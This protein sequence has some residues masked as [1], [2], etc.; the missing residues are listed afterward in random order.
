[1]VSAPRTQALLSIALLLCLHPP[2][3]RAQRVSGG[4][5][6]TSQEQALPSVLRVESN[7]VTVRVVVR[8]KR[9]RAMGG[10]KREDFALFDN[11][12]AQVITHFSVEHRGAPP[13]TAPIAAP[14]ETST[15]A[16][17]RE[18]K[19]AQPSP[20]R[21]LAL[22]FDD[23]HA[24]QGDLN[25]VS[26]AA[27]QYL[28]MA[29]RT[30]ERVGVFTTSGHGELDFTNDLSRLDTAIKSLV[31]RPRHE[32]RPCPPIS[33]YQAYLI[34][35]MNDPTAMDLALSLM[36]NQCATLP[37]EG[38]AHM[39]SALVHYVQ[40]KAHQVLQESEVDARQTFDGFSRVVEHLSERPG[41]RTLLLAS[42]GFYDRTVDY[43]LDPVIDR[44]MRERIVVSAL[45][46]TGLLNVPLFSA[47]KRGIPIGARLADGIRIWQENMAANEEP[48]AALVEATGGDFFHN[49]NDYL[50]G[51]RQI[52]EPPEVLYHLAF[53]PS[54]IKYDGK[55]HEIKVKLA[56]PGG[57]SVQARRGY[58]ALREPL[59]ENQQAEM[60]IRQAIFSTAESKTV[61]V[62][63]ST[64]FFKLEPQKARV[65]LRVR[66]DPRALAFRDDQGRKVDELRITA[67]VFDNSG[68][69]V[70][71]KQKNVKMRFDE[72]GLAKLLE[73]PGGV[74]A[75][76]NLDLAPGNY[77]LREIVLDSNSGNLGTINQ[78]LEIPY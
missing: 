58:F 53:T 16:Q 52:A 40:A 64:S 42:P 44:A 55:F 26:A 41:E 20:E 67:V 43:A 38:A 46:T 57:F 37:K 19:P 76:V 71:G 21:F 5:I 34:T 74:Q 30:G 66:V 28:S 50:A 7:L 15:V 47:D 73:L 36:I 10:L 3:L 25:Q 13:A 8:D 6:S 45:N 65:T 22:L 70:D 59:T 18:A 2:A 62:T 9:G 14:G 39:G 68:R 24:E 60:Q 54:E 72:P 61:P 27:E 4:E 17:P 33:G 12:K 77:R 51:F 29:L 69:L 1:M 11:S 35:E 56:N 49:N 23:L 63:L 78:A 48:L 75:S 32:S 31:P